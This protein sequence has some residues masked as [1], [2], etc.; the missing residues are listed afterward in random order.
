M[1]ACWTS[2]CPNP[3]LLRD[4]S[5]LCGFSAALP[6]R[7][8]GSLLYHTH[9]SGPVQLNRLESRVV[10]K[11][12][13][14]RDRS[15]RVVEHAAGGATH[16]PDRLPPC[17]SYKGP[18]SGKALVFLTNNFGLP[19]SRSPKLYKGRWQVELLFKWIKQN[20][21]IK[22][23]FGTTDNAVRPRYGSPCASMSGGHRLSTNLDLNFRLSQELLQILSV[24]LFE[25]IP[26]AEL[27]VNTQTQ[28]ELSGCSQPIDVGGIN[29]R[30][31]MVT[32]KANSHSLSHVTIYTALIVVRPA[33]NIQLVKNF[34]KTSWP[35]FEIFVHACRSCSMAIS[36]NIC[37]SNGGRQGIAP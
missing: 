32:Y 19:P 3:G 13:G 30:M 23:F 17:E 6:F 9:E 33:D 34:C 15:P 28:N 14:V 35:C 10:D 16:Y 12:F 24:N 1:C 29:G 4:G 36:L 27:V 11:S 37:P 8:G 5:R 7:A 21:R 2:C 20:L 22:H 18:E 25:Q 31:L 26:L